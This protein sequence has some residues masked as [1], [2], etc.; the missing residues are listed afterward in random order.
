MIE[1]IKQAIEQIEEMNDQSVSFV[2]H[3][4][5]SG[6]FEDFWEQI[7]C[8]I[9]GN[10]MTFPIDEGRGVGDLEQ[11]LN[12]INQAYEKHSNSRPD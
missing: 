6:C 3:N 9:E 2:M 4:D 12:F 5:M 11:T 7:P 1:R 10:I 8:E